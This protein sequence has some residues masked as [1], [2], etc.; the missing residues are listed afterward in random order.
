[1]TGDQAMERLEAWRAARG[2]GEY[3]G[4]SRRV[5]RTR[6]GEACVTATFSGGGYAV[7]VRVWSDK[8][9]TDAWARLAD[10]LGLGDG[11]S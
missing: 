4:L 1:M 9:A 10:A 11:E 5:H 6:F 2:P 7:Q 3:R 8:D